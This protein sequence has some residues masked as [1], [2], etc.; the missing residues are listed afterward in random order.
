MKKRL[1]AVFDK[2][3]KRKIKA[4]LSAI[5]SVFGRI[6]NI[7]TALDAQQDVIDEQKAD[8]SKRQTQ[9]K[10]DIDIDDD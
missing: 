4:F 6:N 3:P 7:D 10:Q 1:K 8:Q 9:Q 5:T 2:H